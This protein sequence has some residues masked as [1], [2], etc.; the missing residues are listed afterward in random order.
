M[1]LDAIQCYEAQLISHCL[2]ELA[3]IPRVKVHGPSAQFRSSSVSFTVDGME[4]HGVSRALSNRHNICV[5]SGY[6]CAQPLH[7]ECGIP[8][9]VRA[10]FYLYNELGEINRLV[11]ALEDLTKFGRSQ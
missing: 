1:G 6:H 3:T 8:P 11:T 7:E 4:A 5:R 10:S 2:G 9:T